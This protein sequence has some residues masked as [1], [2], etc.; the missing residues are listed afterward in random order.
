MI[1]SNL[2]LVESPPR[3]LRRARRLTV[4]AAVGLWL[5]L[6][7]LLALTV[8]GNELKKATVDRQQRAMGAASE[9]T[10]YLSDR[11][12]ALKFLADVPSV[13]HR[14]PHLGEALERFRDAYPEFSEVYLADR[15]PSGGRTRPLFLAR[16]LNGGYVVGLLKRDWTDRRFRGGYH[17]R[18]GAGGTRTVLVS[19][20]GARTET[21][22]APP[23]WEALLSIANGKASQVV[24][25]DGQPYITSVERLGE[26]S[27]PHP[28]FLV[29]C[30][31][32]V[33]TILA[34]A[35]HLQWALMIL[36]LVMGLATGA[37]GCVVLHAATR[38]LRRTNRE[39]EAAVAERTAE[40]AAAERS[41]RGIFENAPLGLYQCDP[42]GRFLRINPTLARTL[43]FVD[44]EAAIAALGSLQAVGDPAGRAAFLERLRSGEEVGETTTVYERLDGA[45]LWLE[46]RARVVRKDDGSP[47]LIEGAMHDVTAQRELESQLR[48]MG[49]T[50][51][52]TGLLNRRG[53]TEAIEAAEAPVSFVA[54]DV[55]RFKDYND[56]YGHPA[57]DHALRT[58]AEALRLTVRGNDAVARAGGEEFVVVLPRTGE[59]GARRVAEAL[60]AAVQ[61]CGGLEVRLTVSGGVATAMSPTEVDEAFAAADRAL[62]LAKEAG[63][64]R[65][66]VNSAKLA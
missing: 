9:M 66:V 51:P 36:G 41:F 4:A 44:P 2:R 16:P 57:G 34:K 56:T 54:L 27:K 58:V 52:L 63:R 18:Q 43:G 62:Y 1:R 5:L 39:L 19:R 24:W 42:E 7:G 61:A 29:V 21:S 14:G 38:W 11:L 12:L 45:S 26:L 3:D 65:I 55:D 50:D 46:E 22:A 59:A 32:P 20:G 31:V 28:T 30:A 33:A 23:N 53:L 13:A 8:P 64:N 40:L 10:E 49:E 60:R 47:L 25:G 15:L 48:R 37:V 17:F 35:A 6:A